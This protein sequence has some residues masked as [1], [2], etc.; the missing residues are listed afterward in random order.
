M[1]TLTRRNLK[2]KQTVKNKIKIKKVKRKS[3]ENI[4]FNILKLKN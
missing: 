2:K 3:D 1:T 4:M